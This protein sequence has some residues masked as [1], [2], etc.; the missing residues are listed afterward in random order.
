M[1][2]QF[3]DY[4]VSK[5]VPVIRKSYPDEEH[6]FD[7]R[8]K[9]F[10]TLCSFLRSWRRP[11]GNQLTWV[12]SPGIPNRPQAIV[13]WTISEVANL[14]YINGVFTGDTLA[15]ES[16]GISSITLE[17]AVT[18]DYLYVK[19]GDTKPKKITSITNNSLHLQS[20]IMRSTPINQNSHY[21]KITF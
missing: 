13:N 8:E 16:Q 15:M 10:G 14:R 21:F 3:L 17:T 20:M 12:F 7:Y 6:G 18:S 11:P 1:V 4:M 9:E 19:T 5:G 2:N